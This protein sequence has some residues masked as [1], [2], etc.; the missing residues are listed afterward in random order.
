MSV[1]NTMTLKREQTKS[2]PLGNLI[3]CAIGNFQSQEEIQIESG[4]EA[5]G[6]HKG[7]GVVKIKRRGNVV[8]S[9]NCTGSN[10]LENQNKDFLCRLDWEFRRSRTGVRT[11]NLGPVEGFSSG[12]RCWVWSQGP[13]T[14]QGQAWVGWGLC[15]TGGQKPGQEGS[16]KETEAEFQHNNRKKGSR[17]NR[18]LRSRKHPG[19]C[20][21]AQGSAWLSG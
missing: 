16:R 7:G 20:Q 4:P 15:G 14:D 12:S 9:F 2:F 19:R 17:K 10:D 3:Q 8:R 13:E 18:V 11:H 5:F 1:D 21:Q 6:E